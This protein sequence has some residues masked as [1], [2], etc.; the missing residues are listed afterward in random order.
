MQKM[1]VE[2]FSVH[3]S[4]SLV[5]YGTMQICFAQLNNWL[6]VLEHLAKNSYHAQLE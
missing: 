3:A 6:V 1:S 4:D 2:F 5:T